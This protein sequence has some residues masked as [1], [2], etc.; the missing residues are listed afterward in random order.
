M[1]QYRIDL[2]VSESYTRSAYVEGK[3]KTEAVKKAKDA[4]YR[5][6]LVVRVVGVERLG[7]N[8]R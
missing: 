2:R 4:A 8:G 7:R 5:Q 1:A 6:R 3:T